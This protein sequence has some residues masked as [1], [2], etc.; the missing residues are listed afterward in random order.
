MFRNVYS[1]YK[2]YGVCKIHMEGPKE[3]TSETLFSFRVAKTMKDMLYGYLRKQRE[4][5]G[6]KQKYTLQ[7]SRADAPD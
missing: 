1:K 2:L 5:G 6:F 3:V 7:V 4:T